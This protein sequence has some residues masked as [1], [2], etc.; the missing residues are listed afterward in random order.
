MCS[1]DLTKELH[2]D[3][4]KKSR[5]DFTVQVT[6]VPMGAPGPPASQCDPSLM[7]KLMQLGMGPVC[8]L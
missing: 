2:N 3:Y 5:C 8:G 4:A 7:V 1:W 6:M